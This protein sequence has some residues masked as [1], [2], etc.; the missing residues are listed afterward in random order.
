MGDRIEALPRPFAAVTTD[1]RSG[2]EVVIRDGDVLEAVRASIAIPGIFTP[3]RWRGRLLADGGLTNPLP[4]DV[5]RELG[6]QFVIAVSVL[7]LPETSTTRAREPR[8]LTTQLLARFLAAYESPLDEED[9]D[10]SEEYEGDAGDDMGIIEVLSSATSVIQ[11]RIAAGRLRV[12]PPDHL[13]AVPLGAFGG[14]DYHRAAEAVDAGRSAARE[15]LPEIRN[16]LLAAEPL[17]QKVARWM[18]AATARV[19]LER[20]GDPPDGRE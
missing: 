1:L 6:A 18:D 10:T 13:V 15:A 8:K 16:A 19:G 11:A 14:F 5:A 4:V 9:A 12:E 2:A 7:S 20:E 3:Q 17:A